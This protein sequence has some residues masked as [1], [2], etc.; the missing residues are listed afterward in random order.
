MTN[1][2]QDDFCERF[3]TLFDSRLKEAQTTHM[4]EWYHSFFAK[5]V[6]QI[7]Q[8]DDPRTPVFSL[9]HDKGSVNKRNRAVD[10]L[11]LEIRNL[12]ARDLFRIPGGLLPLAFHP[13]MPD[14]ENPNPRLLMEVSLSVLEYYNVEGVEFFWALN[15]PL[16][17]VARG[18]CRVKPIFLNIN[19][20][21]LAHLGVGLIPSFHSKDAPCWWCRTVPTKATNGDTLRGQRVSLCINKQSCRVFDDAIG[22]SGSTEPR[23]ALIPWNEY[24]KG[25]EDH[26][27]FRLIQKTFLSRLGKGKL[28]SEYK[29]VTDQHTEFH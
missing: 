19:G 1:L 7:L 11:V 23:S 21:L 27:I 15:S 6:W 29:H 18:F 5:G 9:V 26:I 28:H 14:G 3:M 22:H 10:V 24:M 2:N 17:G 13:Y 12:P 4:S 8:R 25:R 16:R 20:D